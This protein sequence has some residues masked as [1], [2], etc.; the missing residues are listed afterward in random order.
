MFV[1]FGQVLQVSTQ[2]VVCFNPVGNFMHGMAWSISASFR[3]W[4]RTTLFFWY[5]HISHFTSICAKKLLF[6]FFLHLFIF[7]FL[8]IYLYIKRI[9][10][11]SGCR[12]W[13]KGSGPSSGPIW[14]WM[15]SWGIIGS[16]RMGLRCIISSS[17]ESCNVFGDLPLVLRG[18]LILT[19]DFYMVSRD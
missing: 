18:C 14:T 1:E 2:L 6:L 12:E 3:S 9:V 17:R 19:W 5:L 4:I 10:Q 11:S 16:R 15:G 8:Y 7:L 13:V